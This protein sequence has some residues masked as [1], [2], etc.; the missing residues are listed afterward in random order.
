[1]RGASWNNNN[2]KNFRGGNRNNNNPQD[3]NNN[4]GLRSARTWPGVFRVQ[5]AKGLQESDRQCPGDHPDPAGVE[6]EG[7]RP[8][9]RVAEGRPAPF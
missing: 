7:G 6:N 3:R 4:N 8:P 2:T 1:M 9:G 5:A